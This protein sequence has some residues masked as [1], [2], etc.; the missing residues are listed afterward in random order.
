M[1]IGEAYRNRGYISVL[2]CAAVLCAVLL[3][4]A[5]GNWK[6]AKAGKGAVGRKKQDCFPQM[7]FAKF[8]VVFPVSCC[9][10]C[11]SVLRALC[12]YVRV[13]PPSI[14]SF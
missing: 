7:L 12:H 8:R 1:E 13:S 4:S 14:L 6:K 11:D 2:R 10:C 9:A 3:S 5:R